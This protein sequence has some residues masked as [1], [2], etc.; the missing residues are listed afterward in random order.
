[1]IRIV[2]SRLNKCAISLS[3]IAALLYPIPVQAQNTTDNPLVLQVRWDHQFQFA[4]YYAAQWLGYYEAEGLNVEIRSAF[5]DGQILDAVTE[6]EQGRAHFGVGAANLLISQDSGTDLKLV[7]SVFQ[8]SAVEYCTLSEYQGNSVFDLSRLHIARRPGDLLDLELQAL[9]FSE[10]I[11]P[12]AQRTSDITRDFTLDDLLAGSFDVVPQFL[13]QISYTASQR[14]IPLKVIRPAEYGIDFYGDTLFTSGNLAEQDP[15][16]VEKFRKASLKGWK[17]ALEHPQEVA[18]KIVVMTAK[19][20]ET[21]EA[22]KERRNFNR[23]QAEKALELTHYPMVEI[24]NINPYRWEKMASVMQS[25]GMINRIPDLDALIFDYDQVR[26]NRLQETKK[27]LSIGLI[28]LIGCLT[29][30]FLAYL[31]WRNTLLSHEIDVRQMAERQLVL[32]NARYETIFRSS[33]LGITITDFD[34][35]IHHVNE[36]WCRMTGY[37]AE[38]LCTMNID[39]LI[40]P[41]STGMD[42][43][44]LTAL[45]DGLI[46]SYSMEKKYRRL[47]NGP[48]DRNFFYGRM[49]LTQ[50]WDPSTDSTLTMSM[51]TDVTRDVLEAEAV[52]RSEDRFRKIIA[53]VAQE[54]GGT[55]SITDLNPTGLPMNLEDINLELERLFTHELEEN[56]RKEALIRSQAR[57]AAMGEMIGYIAHQWRQPLNTLKLVLMNLKDSAQDPDYTEK[58][59]IKANA[60]IKRM[61]ETIDDFRYFSKP[62]TEPRFFRIED[63]MKVVLGL[64]EEHM[65]IAGISVIIDC[66]AL[67]PLFGLENQLSHVL[68]NLLSNSV[69]VLRK[70]P[71]GHPRNIRIRGET[72]PDYSII[73]IEDTG[74]GIPQHISDHVFDMYFSTKE[75]EGGTGLGLYMARA[76][77]ESSFHGSIRL[78]NRPSGCTFEIHIPHDAKVVNPYENPA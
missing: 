40:A 22:L 50:I 35:R 54:I 9:F 63:A 2:R 43:S 31:K 27:T 65:R 53:Q 37:P 17:Y 13:G 73:R 55:R 49:V 78:L 14:G 46:A 57:M 15:E 60:L 21:P 28:I 30:S 10:G 6:V 69:E 71:A 36:A 66:A 11:T 45:K 48:G 41:E 26:M 75:T 76:I 56:R 34:G 52:S 47:P 51:V 19:P 44:Q 29:L 59:Y 77:I 7:A 23:F 64:M 4:G 72:H 12:Y 39:D 8:R 18:D 74:P 5:K 62:R 70:N 3:L 67:S 58:S 32:S 24:G 16:L 61:S 42:S 33:V 1:M 20:D 25:L 68:F 38:Q